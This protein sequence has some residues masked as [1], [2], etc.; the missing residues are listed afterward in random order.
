MPAVQSSK[1]R[2]RKC[3]FVHM[4]ITQMPLI[5]AQVLYGKKHDLEIGDELLFIDGSKPIGISNKEGRNERIS[6]KS[7]TENV[8]CF[9]WEI[10]LCTDEPVTSI[11]WQ[12]DSSM[13]H[14]H[15]S[16]LPRGLN[17]VGVN[18]LFSAN[19]WILTVKSEGCLSFS[20]D[21]NTEGTSAML[22][23]SQATLSNNHM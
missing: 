1:R 21:Q 4:E 19:V 14:M 10:R 20:T 18:W 6:V 23:N 13:C 5:H 17:R 2:R 16:Y 22:S 12:T 11:A 3:T 9:T 7:D 8:S 15:I